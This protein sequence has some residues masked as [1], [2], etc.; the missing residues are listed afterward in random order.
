VN[1]PV[2]DIPGFLDR[3]PLVWSFSLL[4]AFRDI[5]AH[6]AE[7]RYVTKTIKFQETPQT[8][9][10]NEVHSAFEHRIGGNK[11]LPLEMQPWE[12]YAK[13]FDGRGAVAEQWF[14][15]DTDGRAC[16][17][18]DNSKFGHG[19][20]DLTIVNIETAYIGDWKTGKSAYEDPFELEVG[21]VLLHARYPKLK[22]IVGQYF[23]L[24][25]DRP[26]KLYDLSDTAKTWR[27]ICSIMNTV[28]NYRKL[29]EYPKKTSGLCGWC[30]RYD[31]SENPQR[32]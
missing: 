18:F 5:C 27:E 24:A 25:E 32:N 9:W 29:G 28:Y 31:C 11:P 13:G 22:K 12:K 7:A 19:K 10:G 16:E 26:S 4:H 30:Q 6:Q 15:V 21:A 1:A 3:R 17:R 23:W 8:K 2:A 20:L 14:Y